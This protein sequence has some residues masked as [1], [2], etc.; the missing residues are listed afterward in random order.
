MIEEP[1]KHFKENWLNRQSID[2]ASQLIDY[3][4]K[5]KSGDYSIKTSKRP[6][7]QR[8]GRGGWWGIYGGILLKVPRRD[9]R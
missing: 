8:Y 7:S 1:T 3:A 5:S 6:I 9:W 2:L 4:T